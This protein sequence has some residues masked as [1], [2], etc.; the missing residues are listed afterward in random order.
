MKR[1]EEKGATSCAVGGASSSVTGRLGE[2]MTSG[3]SYGNSCV[4]GC[5]RALDCTWKRGNT[6]KYGWMSD[7]SQ[8]LK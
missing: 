8:V 1:A 7:T 6:L 3:D 4:L 2:G 5:N